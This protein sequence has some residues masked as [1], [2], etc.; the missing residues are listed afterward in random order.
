MIEQ[1]VHDETNR[2]W[3]RSERFA[4]ISGEWFFV[5]REGHNIGP[6][7]SKIAASEGFQLY[8]QYIDDDLD[9]G[10]QYAQRVSERGMWG[11]TLCR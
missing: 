3:F 7:P 9:R 1:R 8:L 11:L 4:R 5:T 10:K 2:T 6:F